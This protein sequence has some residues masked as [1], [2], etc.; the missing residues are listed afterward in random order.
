MNMSQ[1]IIH[2]PIATSLQ[3]HHRGGANRVRKLVN[4]AVPFR[5]SVIQATL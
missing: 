4:L 3:F 2:H 1:P 5:G